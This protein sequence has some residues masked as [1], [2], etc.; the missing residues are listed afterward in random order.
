MQRAG[1]GEFPLTL[2]LYINR[3]DPASINNLNDPGEPQ[4]PRSFIQFG[5]VL[6]V[7]V[8]LLAGVPTDA[9][10]EHDSDGASAAYEVYLPW[11]ANGVELDEHGGMDSTIFVQNLEPENSEVELLVGTGVLGGDWERRHY[12]TLRPY[13]SRAIE[14]AQ[15]GIDSGEGASVRVR[16]ITMPSASTSGNSERSISFEPARIAAAVKNAG[17]SSAAGG[18][19]TG[20]H[21]RVDGYSGPNASHVADAHGSHVLPIVQ[22]NSGWETTIRLAHFGE[23]ET[24]GEGPHE[25]RVAFSAAG[26]ELGAHSVLHRTFNLVPGEVTSFKLSN[27]LGRENWV[28]SA[29]ISADVPLGAIAERSKPSERMLMTNLARPEQLD[30]TTQ[31]APLIFRDYFDWNTGIAI[32]NTDPVQ[33]NT[34]EV[35]YYGPDLSVV[36]TD[37]V[38]IAPGG[39][40][41]IHDPASGND[42]SDGGL[43]GSARLTGTTSFQAVVDQVKYT[44]DARESGQGMSYVLEHTPATYA[45]S[46]GAAE[47]QATID[48]ENTLLALP[49]AQRG[50]PAMPGGGDNT[51]I[52]LFNTS[53][54]HAIRL[55]VMFHAADGDPVPPT[56]SENRRSPIMITLGPNQSHT[57]YTP[58]V[59]GFPTGYRGSAIIELTGGGGGVVGISNNV[60]YGVRGDGSAAFGLI[61]VPGALDIGDYV[62][63]P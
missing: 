15:L 54:E 4:L 59:P 38:T 36:G 51:G 7:F 13:E 6:S 21:V 30:T 46:T 26:E 39:M 50:D 18:V 9:A 32:A 61:R 40:N 57:L 1:T 56:I 58:N 28:G 27:V 12:A 37:S 55:E 2:I 25:V 43:V 42:A 24:H 44:D 11:V 20:D 53:S 47:E 63:Q 3:C 19:T 23:R 62:E 17:P 29:V 33:E 14:V 35:T 41:F 22:N 16:G 8:L 52:Q 48:P 45:T 31:Y 5:I 10:A 60:N 49:L 34:V